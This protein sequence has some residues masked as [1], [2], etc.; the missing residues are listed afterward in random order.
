MVIE[1]PDQDKYELM[2]VYDPAYAQD[3]KLLKYKV[4]RKARAVIF[5]F[6]QRNTDLYDKPEDDIKRPSLGRESI[7]GGNTGIHFMTIASFRE[8]RHKIEHGSPL[9]IRD[10]T[11]I[12]ILKNFESMKYSVPYD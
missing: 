12:Y 8:L 6:L 5:F 7:S 10:E 9:L 11:S 4:S 1:M 3:V 2:R